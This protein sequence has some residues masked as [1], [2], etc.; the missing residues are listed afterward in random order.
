MT[1]D[2]APAPVASPARPPGLSGWVEGGL[3]VVVLSVLNL[4]YAVSHAAGAHPVV[5]IAVAMVVAAF[6]LLAITGL[7]KD[8]RQ[9]ATTPLSW[10][11]GSCIIVMEAVYYMLLKYVSPADGSMLVRLTVPMS[12]MIG[13]VALGRRPSRGTVAGAALVTIGIVWY[14][15]NLTP[16]SRIL[17][18]T[19]ATVCA[20]IMN[21]RS[22]AAEFHPQNRAAST[23]IEK[24]RVTGVVL[25]VTSITGMT[26]LAG[27]MGLVALG[28]IP[29][30]PAL[31]EIRH[32]FHVPTLL[33]A[34]FVG[35][36]VLTSMQYLAFSTV[37]KIRTE[38]FMAVNA[39]TP[40]VTLGLQSIAVA[41]GLHAPFPFDWWS[42][43]PMTVVITGVLAVISFARRPN[44]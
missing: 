22:Y 43:L 6:S 5:F 39:F 16:E 4:A 15:L 42:L 8:W 30:T 29:A 13:A 17:G 24:M 26:V 25:F 19:I 21:T 44:V 37:V 38:N 34:L 33:V 7:G 18:I 40:V 11:I 28:I 12:I 32:F 35:V 41:T 31:P 20:V 3:Y 36:L 9:I 14:T 1:V 2:A 10:L 27:L 23:I